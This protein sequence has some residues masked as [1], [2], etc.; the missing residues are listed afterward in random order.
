MQRT[1]DASHEQ[2]W[3][4][5]RRACRQYSRALQATSWVRVG[6]TPAPRLSS[7][8][9]RSI[10]PI[11]SLTQAGTNA[12]TNGRQQRSIVLHTY[13]RPLSQH[14]QGMCR[15]GPA[16]GLGVIRVH[17]SRSAEQQQ[18]TCV[19]PVCRNESGTK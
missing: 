18:L 2:A 11:C 4:G 5:A 9:R 10:S 14:K 15:N 3:Y 13:E 19:Y 6:G 7:V 17:A 8:G 1:R 12:G 16:A